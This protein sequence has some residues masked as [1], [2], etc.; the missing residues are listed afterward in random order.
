MKQVKIALARFYNAKF[1]EMQSR[2]EIVWE[3]MYQGIK[4]VARLS[5][6]TSYT[7]WGPV[8]INV[9]KKESSTLDQSAYVHPGPDKYP[10]EL[11]MEVMAFKF[12]E[13]LDEQYELLQGGDK[14]VI[15]DLLKLFKYHESGMRNSIDYCA[16]MIGLQV[17]PELVTVPIFEVD[18]RYLF[19]KEKYYALEA[20]FVIQVRSSVN[21]TYEGKGLIAHNM[22]NLK[23]AK[24]NKV[25]KATECLS[26]LL[27]GWG[28]D[29]YV[30][31]F[32]SFFAALESVMPN[33]ER[34][35]TKVFD[36][37]RAKLIL[38]IKGSS[39]KH[40]LTTENY[41]LFLFKHLPPVS[42]MDRFTKLAS[43]AKLD[44]WQKD[45]E[46]FRDYNN[47]RNG[48]LHRGDS[49]IAREPHV[50]NNKLKD[51]E[52][53]TQKYIRCVLYGSTKNIPTNASG[54]T[55]ISIRGNFKE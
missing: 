23:L 47:I 29:D 31:R 26:W 9:A 48:I 3:Q 35:D 27:R 36:E 38:I 4:V 33:I 42:L 45:I 19:I 54:K 8:T 17:N 34:I 51:F 44:N 10:A 21:I 1:V 20:G 24:T 18:Q 46:D 2:E 52:A 32:I 40:D 39:L 15:D 13:V 5:K 16:G 11:Y 53:L 41:D 28:A 43:K 55:I 25:Q 6:T 22:N 12:I 14:Q 50:D 49:R 30:L 37:V 7:K